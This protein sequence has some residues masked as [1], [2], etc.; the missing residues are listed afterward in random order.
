MS[1]GLKIV[2]PADV[3][4]LARPAVDAETL[5]AAARIVSR[6]CAPVAKPPCAG[7]AER[8]DDAAARCAAAH[9]PRDHL[10]AAFHRLP[11][12]ASAA[13]PHRASAFERFASAQRG[14][15]WR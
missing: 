15:H 14:G 11:R 4:A 10:A 12:R 9:R 1:V 2:T 8:F 7:Y 6:R 13:R 5:A 3:K